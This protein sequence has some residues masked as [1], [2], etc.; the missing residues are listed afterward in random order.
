MTQK[1]Y[2]HLH[3]INRAEA[4]EI[5]LDAVDAT[6]EEDKL[7][8]AIYQDFAQEL[9]LDNHFLL[10]GFLGKNLEGELTLKGGFIETV[11]CSYGYQTKLRL[12]Q[13]SVSPEKLLETVVAGRQRKPSDLVPGLPVNIEAVPLQGGWVLVK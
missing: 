12:S 13:A 5:G 1:Q 6:A 4:K 7:M 9:D 2:S 3:A 11:E 8:W 10:R